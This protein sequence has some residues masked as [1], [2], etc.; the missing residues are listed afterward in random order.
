MIA[1]R[2][3]PRYFGAHFW[4]GDNV[5]L[6]QKLKIISL[7]HVAT[8]ASTPIGALIE[9]TPDDHGIPRGTIVAGTW[10]IF[11]DK[12]FAGTMSPDQFSHTFERFE[13]TEAE[14]VET[15]PLALCDGH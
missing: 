2:T 3:K 13:V 10:V 9:T 12:R 7:A 8:P 1:V 14:F 5:D 11:T 4:Q 15:L 6:N